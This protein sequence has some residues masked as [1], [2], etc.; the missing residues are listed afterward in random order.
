MNK[1]TIKLDDK[2][3]ISP[4]ISKFPGG[5]IFINLNIS[6]PHETAQIKALLF[7]SDDI[8]TLIMLI[9]ALR[10]FKIHT[11][12]VIIPY[13]PY[14]R[15]D[16]ICNIGESLSI[17]AFAKII[18]SLQLNSVTI[19]DPHSDVTPALIN[20]CIIKSRVDCMKEHNQLQSWLSINTPIYLVS[21]DAGSVKKSYDIV[22]S[23]PQFK[24]II[25][26][27]KLR[28]V[29]TG[30]IIKTI[31]NHIPTDISNSKILICDDIGDGCF[32]FLKLAEVF[33]CHNP[34]D[35]SLYITHG[36]FSKGKD[37]LLKAKNGPFDNVWSTIDFTSF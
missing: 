29:S 8:M 25:F 37:I 10:E 11:I 18:N 34:K 17:R 30:K 36:I 35:I 33:L 2:L 5:E 3:F 12:D 31:V 24:D 27:E 20:N 14:A 4:K 28:E 15:Q 7:N 26:A 22:K 21:P 32:T 6:L 19:Y 16:R 13:V 1:F 23:F 9:D